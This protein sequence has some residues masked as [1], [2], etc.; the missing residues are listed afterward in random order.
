MTPGNSSI[1]C[2]FA[3]LFRVITIRL[4]I[5]VLISY[6]CGKHCPLVT[7]ICLPHTD[8]PD[9]SGPP[10]CSWSAAPDVGPGGVGAALD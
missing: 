5:E 8:H 3:I 2:G 7:P 9:G 4:F 10:G 6:L 1:T